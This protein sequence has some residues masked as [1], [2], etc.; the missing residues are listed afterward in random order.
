MLK[1]FV[2]S[3]RRLSGLGLLLVILIGF[4]LLIARHQPSASATKLR[5]VA[6]Y[7]PLFDIASRVGGQWASV[8]VVTPAG[9][10]PHDYEPTPQQLVNLQQ[11]DVLLYNGAPFEPWIPSFLKDYQHTAIAA[12]QHIDLLPVS[13]DTA[14][15][16]PD[17]HFWLDPV[18]AQ[19]ITLTVRDAFI[20]AD[21]RHADDYN[22]QAAAY[23]QQLQQLDGQFS[24]G[25]ANCRILQVVSSHQALRYV[26]KRYNFKVASIAG[27]SPEAEPSPAALAALSQLIRQQGITTVL[28]ETLVSPKLATTLA[29]EAGATTAVFDP[30][31]GLT[32][33][34]QADG[35]NY[36]SIQRQNLSV[37]ERAMSCQ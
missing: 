18:L 3:P 26:A 8:E 27:I 28:F 9:Q 20:S 1:G 25:L 21:P 13:D 14:S 29:D 5:V 4:G 6:T 19:Q 30:I 31:E 32:D 37:L 11:S 23:L 35:A 10:E 33:K 7:Y 22:Q 17:P 12:S 24:R 36:L 15:T 2:T 16:T 34:E